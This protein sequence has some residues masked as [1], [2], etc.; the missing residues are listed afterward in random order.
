MYNYPLLFSRTLAYTELAMTTVNQVVSIPFTGGAQLL[1]FH[2][3]L[4][5]GNV[6]VCSKK[7]DRTEFRVFDAVS[8]ACRSHQV[9]LEVSHSY[10]SIGCLIYCCCC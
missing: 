1:Y 5:A 2:L 10:C 9:H 6:E 3:A 4:L 8:V 7:P